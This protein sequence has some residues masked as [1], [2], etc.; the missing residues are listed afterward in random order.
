[1]SV[2]LV[3]PPSVGWAKAVNREGRKCYLDAFLKD[4]GGVQ[5]ARYFPIEALGLASIQAFGRRRGL[6]IKV[7]NAI[8]SYHCSVEETWDALVRVAARA[9]APVL[10]GFTGANVV[11]EE[12][13]WLAGRCRDRWPGVRVILGSDFATMNAERLLNECPE[14]DFVCLGD[15]ELLVAEL[16]E[17]L[18][19]GG[20]GFAELAGLAYRDERGVPCV[21][22]A[23]PL[24]LDALPWAERE[25]VHVAAL[26]GFGAAVSASRGCPYQCTFCSTAGASR[27]KG[28]GGGWRLRSPEAVL[29][30]VESLHKD[31]GVRHVVFTDELFLIDSEASRERAR[32]FA[33]GFLKRHLDVQFMFDC[34]ADA[35]EPDLF[36]HLARAGLRQVFVGL[37]SGHA[38]QMARYRKAYR[39]GVDPASQLRLV[40]D[41]GIR[42]VPGIITFH[43]E[44]TL[45][46]LRDTYRLVEGFPCD[47]LFVFLN[48]VNPFPGTR[49]WHEYRDKGYLKTE[50]PVAEF[51]FQDE[52]IER[53]FTEIWRVA[54]EPGASYARLKEAFARLLG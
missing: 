30:E 41:L 13:L 34:R 50:W 47:K 51:A 19:R 28:H 25:E 2:I 37:E 54:S 32:A 12:N 52:R 35:I 42:V 6:R 16:A 7:V 21:N 31:H 9:G 5:N 4:V 8:A 18:N 49:L 40:S 33:E 48:R 46:E 3:A 15:G 36:A 43:A 29:D 39:K 20:G 1:M 17:R 38:G 26:H 24:E 11:L 14:V 45:E 44:T 53:I 10:V 22:A 23:S 27:K